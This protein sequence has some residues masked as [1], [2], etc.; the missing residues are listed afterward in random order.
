MNDIKE[1]DLNK[2]IEDEK[3]KEN[4]TKKYISNCFINGEIKTT[5]TEINEIMPPIS[6]FSKNKESRAT[7]KQSVLNKFLNFFD[8]FWGT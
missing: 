3:L 7:K 8:K 1:N 6:R 2:I 5:G 4:E